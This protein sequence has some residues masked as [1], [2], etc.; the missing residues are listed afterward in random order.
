MKRTLMKK[1]SQIS[2][3]L[4]PGEQVV[5]ALRAVPGGE[6]ERLIGRAAGALLGGVAGYA[7][8]DKLGEQVAKESRARAEAVGVKAKGMDCLLVLTDRRLLVYDLGTRGKPRERLGSIP[9]G[10]IAD[11][12]EGE[13][14]IV[15]PR[16]PAIQITTT[17]GASMAFGVAKL[18]R[19][20]LIS[21]LDA[22]RDST[23]AGPPSR[24]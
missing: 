19:S 22:Y 14:R 7:I 9:L 3:E 11:L 17:S 2:D 12:T 16:M 1:V 4:E 10:E 23:S 6:V 15:G 21:F 18:R 20:E 8:G 5:E 24:S 13:V